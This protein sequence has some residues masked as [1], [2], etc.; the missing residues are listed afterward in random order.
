MKISFVGSRCGWSSRNACR[1]A[2]TSG[3]SSSRA[4]SVFF[5]ASNRSHGR[6]TTSFRSRRVRRFS[7]PTPRFDRSA[8]RRV[9][10]PTA[11]AAR[12]GRCVGDCSLRGASAGR[13]QSLGVVGETG[14]RW[15]LR[16]RTTPPSQ[17]TFRSFQ[18]GTPP[19]NVASDRA[20]DQPSPCLIT[21]D[22]SRQFESGLAV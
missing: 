1:F 11:V 12:S 21:T 13:H 7:S 18:T 17:H 20:N 15:P 14:S 10:F 8:D 19:P 2:R 5:Y 22:R 16:R 9:C 6:R 3:R 4:I